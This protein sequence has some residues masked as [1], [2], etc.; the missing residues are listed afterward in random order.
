MP[1][2]GRNRTKKKMKGKFEDVNLNRKIEKILKD[3]DVSKV[4]ELLERYD[5]WERRVKPLHVAADKGHVGVIKVLIQNGADVNRRDESMWTPIQCASVH[6]Y[7]DVVKLLIRNGADV[8]AVN[9]CNWTSLHL[10]ASSGRVGVTKLLVQSGANV[11]A[12]NE[13]HKTSLHLATQNGYDGVAMVLMQNGADVNAL[14]ENERSALYFTSCWNHKTLSSALTL[15]CF[16]AKIDKKALR[17]DSTGLFRKIEKKIKKLR[18]R[19]HRIT[20]LYSKEEV[21]FMWNL[22]FCMTKKIK[23]VAFKA[24]YMISSFISFNGIFMAPGFGVGKGS[25]W[26]LSSAEIHKRIRVS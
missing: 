12:V 15:L 10:A 21:R 6:G 3:G 9:I 25:I 22:A 5:I 20:N 18:A 8:N 24:Y 14:D 11:N 26:K 19:D 16:G 7:G 4:R 13:H 1:K 2:K 23:G 17:W